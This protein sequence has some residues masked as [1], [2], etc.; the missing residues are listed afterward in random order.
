MR[1]W[2]S[3]RRGG[4]CGQMWEG[5]GALKGIRVRDMM[6]EDKNT[7]YLG[8]DYLEVLWTKLRGFIS[9][10]EVISRKTLSPG[11]TGEPESR[12]IERQGSKETF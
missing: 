10:G 12:L 11:I 2:V 6:C 3:S 7:V 8:S 1:E 4:R 5:L 9:C